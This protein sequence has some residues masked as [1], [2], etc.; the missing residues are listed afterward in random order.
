M[1]SGMGVVYTLMNIDRAV[2][3]VWGSRYDVRGMLRASYY[4]IDRKQLKDMDL[5][6]T[7]R[8]L[9][10]KV[11]KKIKGTDVEKLL[12]DSNLI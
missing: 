2:P 5:S 4:A 12:K 11:L 6:L 9:L 8:F 7:E 1:R 3:E 10:K